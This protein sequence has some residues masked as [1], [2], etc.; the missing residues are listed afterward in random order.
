MERIRRCK[1]VFEGRRLSKV[2]FGMFTTDLLV[3]LDVGGKY[4][5]LL[6]PFAFID[7]DGNRFEV[8]IGYT[9]N[10]ASF[11]A[12][13]KKLKMLGRTLW[14]FFGSPLG[15]FWTW[16]SVLHDYYCDHGKRLGIGSDKVHRMFYDA[17]LLC[18]ELSETSERVRKIERRKAKKMY[19]GVK[20]FGKK[21]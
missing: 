14:F 7:T 20:T 13:K 4:I 16:G 18:I 10:G 12:D 11:D 2:G 21:W 1:G 19:F 5:T 3:S 15:D 6:S 17:M 8:P 9:A